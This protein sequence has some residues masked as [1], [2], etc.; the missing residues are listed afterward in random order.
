M[1]S[2]FIRNFE[3][4]IVYNLCVHFGVISEKYFRISVFMHVHK[5]KTSCSE[6]IWENN[7]YIVNLLVLKLFHGNS[8]E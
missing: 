5:K 3:C 2:F 6:Q 7:F 8:P 4:T 1:N